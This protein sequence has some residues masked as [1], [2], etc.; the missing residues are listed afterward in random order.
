MLTLAIPVAIFLFLKLF[1][2]N[3]FIVPYLFENGI[4][5]CSNSRAPHTVPEFKY[6]GET[7]KNLSSAELTGFLVF[8][9]LDGSLIEK[10]KKKIIEIVRIQ[11][12][13]FEI[14]SPYFVLFVYP[15]IE[16]QHEL[17]LL[18]AE[19]GLDKKNSMLAVMKEDELMDFLK[20]GIAL[21][22]DEVNDFNNLV[23]VD[24]QKKIRGIYNG[25]DTEQ[26]DQLILEL[27]ILK[28]KN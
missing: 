10:N 24:E 6:I 15:K 23:L 2:T 22:N 20:C 27:K 8:G 26:T 5:G 21:I 12:A 9:V 17:R 13:F 11:D 3:T 25:M 16:N 4:P 28:Q 7:E 19:M 18:C 1:G 14:G